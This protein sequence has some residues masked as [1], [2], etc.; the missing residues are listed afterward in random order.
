M[1]VDQIPNNL[2]L[3]IIKRTF[4]KK[5]KCFPIKFG[6]NWK[7]ITGRNNVKQIVKIQQATIICSLKEVTEKNVCNYT[8]V[9]GIEKTIKLFC[10]KKKILCIYSNFLKNKFIL[11]MIVYCSYHILCHT[12]ND[13]LV[14]CTLHRNSKILEYMLNVPSFSSSRGLFVGN[15][16]YQLP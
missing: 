11:V 4:S 12:G 14:S 8:T 16:F 6:G 2:G 3:V 13:H 15:S 5:S 10:V 1:I 7:A 9:K